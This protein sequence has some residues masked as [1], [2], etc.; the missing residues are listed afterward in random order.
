MGTNGEGALTDE[1]IDANMG[2][3]NEGFSGNLKTY[4]TDCEGN[5][6]SGRETSIRFTLKNI[7]RITN[8]A[9]FNVAYADDT[10]QLEI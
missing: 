10:T 8:D 6:V 5:P 9:W 7:N 2:Y 3:L 4:N 1:V